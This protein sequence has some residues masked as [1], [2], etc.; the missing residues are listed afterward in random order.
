M[1]R[2]ARFGDVIG[3]QLE[4]FETDNAGDLQE[5]RDLLKMWRAAGRDEAEEA[6]GDVIDAVDATAEILTDMRDRFASTLAEP[7]AEQYGQEFNSTARRRLPMLARA[8]ED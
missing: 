3:R 6:F 1:F 8:L 4:L 5:I 2:R 7:Q